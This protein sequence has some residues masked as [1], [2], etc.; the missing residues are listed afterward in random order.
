MPLSSKK[1]IEFIRTRKGS[2]TRQDLIK[3]LIDPKVEKARSGK[4][5][6]KK[7]AKKYQPDRDVGRI[8]ETVTALLYTGLLTRQKK[9]LH[10]HHELSLDAVLIVSTSG[11]GIA[12]SDEGDEI[13]IKE[14]NTG[15]G[16]NNDH[17]SVRIIDFRRGYFY[18]EVT[19]ILKRHRNRYMARFNSMTKGMI[20]YR[21]SDLPGEI[22]VVIDRKNISIPEKELT[23]PGRFYIVSLEEKKL[24]NRQLCS[25]LDSF[26]VTDERFDLSRITVRHSLPGEHGYYPELEN[27]EKIIEKEESQRDDYRN[28]FTV[29]IDGADAKDFDDAISLTKE[30]KN[31][32]LLVHIADVSTFV[33]IGGELDAEAF[34]RG[35][36]YYLGSSVIPMLPEQLSNELCSLKQN[37]DRLTLTAS[38]LI[39]PEGELLDSSFHQ[40][41]IKVNHRLT[42]TGTE[43]I[44]TG[45]GTD[46]LERKMRQMNDLA[47]ILYSKRIREGRIDLNLSDRR[48]VYEDNR[49][50]GIE[51][52]PRLR[53]HRIVEECMLTAN[54]AA[55]KL[56]KEKGIPSLYRVHEPTS[57]EK[58]EGL[59]KFLKLYDIKL[60][61]TE[62]PGIAVQR[63]IE[64]IAGNENDEMIN[65]VILKSMMQAFY[66]NEP[67][68][69]FGLGFDD[70]THFTSPI[71]RYPDLIVHRCLAAHIRGDKNPYTP[72][73]L[74]AMGE[75][76]SDLERVAQR[77]ERD[78]VKLKSCRLMA[79]RIG[80]TFEATINGVT[81]FGFYVALDDPHVE[82]MVPMRTLTDDYYIVQ[83]DEFTL[84]GKRLGKRF[85]I[86]D[87]VT[88]RCNDVNMEL[89]RIDFEVA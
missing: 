28:Q 37:V 57:D 87:R 7:K 81:K 39:S 50:K 42:Y 64:K 63:V 6:K 83:E 56:L 5:A 67:L 40:G 85:R 16:H 74:A 54:M 88:V 4:Q 26:A 76:S 70:Y 38:M 53:S 72:S 12:L 15:G 66:G 80:D 71:R 44:L 55:A 65:M 10:A 59:Q 2:F 62:D 18:G 3:G 32:R 46:T 58:L 9:K 86:G 20:I 73:Q 69:H 8:E 60:F 14:T 75:Q 17:V 82:G 41:I 27:I 79:D 21:L 30:D 25:I 35:T 47:E 19:G 68:G 49:V 36:S 23:D 31:F 24:G 77:A 52:M 51:I 29:T 78:M 43:E 1:I 11:D 61:I 33:K 13:I 34:D 45:R 89:F 22:E 84:V 48:I